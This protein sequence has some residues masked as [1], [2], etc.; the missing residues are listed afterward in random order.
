MI[1]RV[2]FVNWGVALLVAAA[3]LGAQQRVGS[4]GRALD[5]SLQAGQRINALQ[6]P[7]NQGSYNT[8]I[9]NINSSGA[10]SLS[11]DASFT[12]YGMMANPS[13][14]DD[15][16]DAYRR[17]SPTNTLS[18][19]ATTSGSLMGQPQVNRYGNLLPGTLQSSRQPDAVQI[20]LHPRFTRRLFQP[21]QQLSGTGDVPLIDS[22]SGQVDPT[23]HVV[24]VEPL[25]LF[26][27]PF[28]LRPLFQLEEHTA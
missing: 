10:A 20:I 26:E 7:Q 8:A 25:R 23:L 11:N 21:F 17:Y 16:F 5:G 14:T 9:Q 22:H 13:A 2:N 18:L 24:G 12:R 19:G 1:D 15:V 3:P 27:R 4:D 6:G 28:G